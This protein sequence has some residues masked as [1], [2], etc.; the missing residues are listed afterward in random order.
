MPISTFWN[1][2]RLL[3]PGLEPLITLGHG[4]RLDRAIL[5][6]VDWTDDWG[7]AAVLPGSVRS[8]ETPPLS[9]VRQQLPYRVVAYTASGLQ[10]TAVLAME[11]ATPTTDGPPDLRIWAATIEVLAGLGC[12]RL[13]LLGDGWLVGSASEPGDFATIVD[14]LNWSKE[15]ILVGYPAEADTPSRF[16]DTQRL[17]HPVMGVPRVIAL[18]AQPPAMQTPA[19]LALAARLGATAVTGDVVPLA[20]LGH[21]KGMA[22]TALLRTRGRV[23]GRGLELTIG[24]PA[25]LAG[26]LAPTAPPP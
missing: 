1:Q 12:R 22:V 20:L 16:I 10:S 19:E 15:N 17:Y 8:V 9:M 5:W 21:F 3:T 24:D 4:T 6:P 23:M 11:A 14:H 2:V 26:V 25:L 7:P 18:Y 13:W